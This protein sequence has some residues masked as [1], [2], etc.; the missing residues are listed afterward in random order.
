MHAG[1]QERFKHS[2]PP[3]RVLDTFTPVHAHPST[4]PG[5]LPEASKCRINI[6]FRFFRPDFKADTV[7][8]CACG[9]PTIL[10]PDARKRG[11]ALTNG[12]KAQANLD[13]NPG[14]LKLEND[15][16]FRY[17]WTCNGAASND[18]KGCG[19]WRVMDIR[20]EGRGPFMIDVSSPEK[21]ME[22]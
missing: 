21:R 18:G 7:P 5:T 2:V 8:K 3:Q 13:T 16:P 19:F 17:W 4:S 6:T 12:N 11:D 1:C 20:S 15:E 9:I 10:R 22:F 14:S